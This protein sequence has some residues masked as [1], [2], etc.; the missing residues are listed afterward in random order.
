MNKDTIILIAQNVKR[1]SIVT[2]HIQR[3]KK[4]QEFLYDEYGIMMS[5]SD[6]KKSSLLKSEIIVNLDF[7][8]ELVNQYNIYNKAIIINI[9]EKILIYKKKFNGININYFKIVMPQ[10]YELSEFENEIVYESVISENKELVNIRYRILKDEI[11]IKKLIGNN[12][13]IQESEII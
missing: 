4:I 1:L 6:N 2:N 10:E 9:L 5:I 12:G 13:P 3:F 8:E 7:P 11:A